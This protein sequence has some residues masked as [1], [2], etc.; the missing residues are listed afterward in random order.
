MGGFTFKK[1]IYLSVVWQSSGIHTTGH[2]DRIT[3]NVVLWFAGTNDAGDNRSDIHSHPEGEIVVR[4][5]IDA[6]EF[7]FHG[8]NKFHQ[9]CQVKRSRHVGIRLSLTDPSHV[10]HETDS[11]AI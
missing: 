1:Q 4:I 5:L 2:I 7:L 10:R 6:K 8:E 9:S 11:P 3:P